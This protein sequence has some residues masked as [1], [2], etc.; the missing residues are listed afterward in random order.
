[1]KKK[2]KK[3][4]GFVSITPWRQPVGDME[5]NTCATS[6]SKPELNIIIHIFT[7]YRRMKN[8]K[9]HI[10]NSILVGKLQAYTGEKLTSNNRRIVVRIVSMTTVAGQPGTTVLEIGSGGC[11]ERVRYRRDAHRFKTGRM[12]P[13]RTCIRL[14]IPRSYVWN[15]IHHQLFAADEK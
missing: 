13:P 11:V 6:R 10:A 3:P 5:Q 4:L 15:V 12:L 7:R 8:A 1:M 2:P 9:S 14:R